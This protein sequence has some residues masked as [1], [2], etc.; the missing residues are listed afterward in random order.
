[1]LPVQ[2]DN[3]PQGQLWEIAKATPFE[4]A[5]VPYGTMISLKLVFL[6]GSLRK[7]FKNFYLDLGN[8]YFKTRNC[9]QKTF[10]LAAESP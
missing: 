6:S 1:M 4:K 2:T 9:M 10:L 8:K 3:P 5:R 7:P